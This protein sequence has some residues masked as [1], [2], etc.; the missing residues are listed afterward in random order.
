MVRE[1]A[2]NPLPPITSS[3]GSVDNR[4]HAGLGLPGRK[5]PT[6]DSRCAFEPQNRSQ[7]DT[8][9]TDTYIFSGRVLPERAPLYTGEFSAKVS[10][11]DGVPE[12]NLSIQITASQVAARFV[13]ADAVTNIHTLRNIVEDATRTL[14]DS[15]GFHR[16]YAYDLE[17]V[18]MIRPNW[19]EGR[20]FGINVPV[21][22]EACG[23]AG[24]EL[25]DIVAKL[26]VPDGAYLR[27]S[28]AD[29]REAI[30]SPRD[31]GFFCYRAIE[32]LKNCVAA[33]NGVS[34]EDGKGWTLFRES[35]SID[36]REIDA[37]KE[38]ADPA[39]HGDLSEV[40]Q[41]TD[42]ARSRI[43]TTTWRIVARFI[44]KGLRLSEVDQAIPKGQP[45]LYEIWTLSGVPLK[46]GIAEDL[47]QRL[48]DHRASRQTRLQLK[49][50]GSWSRPE[51][52]V[53]KRSILAKH[54]HFDR[55][56]APDYDLACE[57]GRRGFLEDCCEVRIHPTSNREEARE[58]EKQREATGLFRYTG[59]VRARP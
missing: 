29:L 51:D 40:K 25:Q 48:G 34:S 28:L 32:S 35:Y 7:V 38:F 58:L 41:L 8:M 54:L 3:D 6:L 50:G 55:E 53:S 30:K 33:G 49:S 39:R 23:Q 11:S 52:V 37:I 10:P 15:I 26:A 46:V 2:S 42:D 45:G 22:A 24:L 36:K 57:E 27:H 4:A 56:L 43:F 21:L 47:R 19:S 12:G 9:E 17:I 44:L 18:Q 14:L 5:E 59:R 1:S 20:V 31:T 16:G 13:C